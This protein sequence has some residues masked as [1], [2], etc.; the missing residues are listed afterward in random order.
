MAWL[1][2]GEDVLAAA[3]KAVTRRDRRVGLMGRDD[4]D[5]V[6][7][8]QPCRQVHTFGMRFAIDVAFCDRDG[9]VLHTSTMPPYRV[10][11]PVLRA[12]FAIEARAG[13]FDRWKLIPGDVV[14]VRG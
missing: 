11:K 9:F 14:E 13:S 4:V 7:V 5:G 6:F 10:S 8:L 2:R 3:E 1:V 12:Q